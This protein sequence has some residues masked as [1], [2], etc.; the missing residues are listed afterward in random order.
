LFE[1]LLFERFLVW[2]SLNQFCSNSYCCNHFVWNNL[3][4]HCWDSFWSKYF[5]QKM[6]HLYVWNSKFVQEDFCNF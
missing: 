1:K 6:S 2:T 4:S 5:I 3:N